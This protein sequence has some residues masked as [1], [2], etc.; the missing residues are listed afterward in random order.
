[1]IYLMNNVVMEPEISKELPQQSVHV[2]SI[3]CVFFQH[4]HRTR[5]NALLVLNRYRTEAPVNRA[6]L[7]AYVASRSLHLERVLGD[8]CCWP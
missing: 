7:P 8:V 6:V 1:M 5:E 2:G 4:G 3:T